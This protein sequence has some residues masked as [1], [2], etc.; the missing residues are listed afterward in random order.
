LLKGWELVRDEV[1]GNN[2]L[3][4]RTE[5]TLKTIYGEVSK[6]L[7]NLTDD[8]LSLMTISDSD[9]KHLV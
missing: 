5:I 2:L 9:A 6:R 3:Q 1:L 4:A 8:E 7:K